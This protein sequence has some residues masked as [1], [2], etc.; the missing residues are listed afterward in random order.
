[1]THKPRSYVI[2]AAT[3]APHSESMFDQHAISVDIV[4][5]FLRDSMLKYFVILK[6]FTSKV[7]SY[8]HEVERIW[9]NIIAPVQIDNLKLTYK[10]DRNDSEYINLMS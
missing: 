6:I 10:C 2:L 4:N 3:F 7:L 1:M 8:K 5:N 9:I